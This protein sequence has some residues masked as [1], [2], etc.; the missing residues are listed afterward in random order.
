VG[1]ATDAASGAVD[2]ATDAVSGAVGEAG[3]ALGDATSGATDPVTDAVGDAVD[4]VG[5]TTGEVLDD[6]TG[7]VDGAVDTVDDAV[8]DPVDTVGDTVDDAVGS[9]GTG[10]GSTGGPTPS[11]GPISRERA[12]ITGIS[13][14]LQGQ[15]GGGLQAAAA[16]AATASLAT[17]S[18]PPVMS[19]K[20]SAGSA[21]SRATRWSRT[22][23]AEAAADRGRIDADTLTGNEAVLAVPE[24]PLAGN[25]ATSGTLDEI[26]RQAAAAATK[27]TFPLLLA[28][29]VLGFI[30]IQ[31]RLD[32]RDPKLALAPI[33]SEQ[34]VLYFE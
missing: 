22:H 23:A 16:T 33:D 25:A 13:R 5:E 27:L 31:G 19:V 28:L 2:G 10:S 32:R 29:A 12:G 21:R 1:D 26:L 7:V 3:D 6:A 30:S 24:A 14:A 15:T 8:T 17:T 34:E 9:G 4:T 20:A 18:S 11:E